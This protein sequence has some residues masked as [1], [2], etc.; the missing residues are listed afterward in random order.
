MAVEE[1]VVERTQQ[2]PGAYLM[3]GGYVDLEQIQILERRGI[4]VYAPPKESQKAVTWKPG[5]RPELTEWRERMDTRE[6]KAIYRHRA[7]TA[8]CVNALVRAKYGLQ[9]FRVRGLS[10]VISV[11]L[12]VVITHNLMRW[13]ALSG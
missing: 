5:T 10:N 11:V 9:Q 6:G 8:E 4:K 7:S 12:L 2:D 13:A 1:Q 3:D